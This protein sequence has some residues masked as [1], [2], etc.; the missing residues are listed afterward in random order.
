MPPRPQIVVDRPGFVSAGSQQSVPSVPS[1][2]VTPSNT[3]HKTPHRSIDRSASLVN[4]QGSNHRH[5]LSVPSVSDQIS[6]TKVLGPTI[7]KIG[8]KRSASVCLQVRSKFEELE[9]LV[10]DNVDKRL[11]SIETENM[12]LM[13]ELNFRTQ[14]LELLNRHLEENLDNLTGFLNVLGAKEQEIDQLCT[15]DIFSNLNDLNSRLDVVKRELEVSK[16][17]LD[18]FDADL[19]VVEGQKKSEIIARGVQH[20]MLLLALLSVVVLI[21]SIY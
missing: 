8:R 6:P 13:K 10:A 3:S 4:I 1:L 11:E 5:Y 2:Y 9:S 18:I 14:D 19:R 7:S 20:N 16:A 12:N 15:S 21:I 17:K